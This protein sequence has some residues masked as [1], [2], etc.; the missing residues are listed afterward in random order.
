MKDAKDRKARERL[1]ADRRVAGK[2]ITLAELNEK[3]ERQAGCELFAGWLLRPT[4]PG[5]ARPHP[6][7]YVELQDGVKEQLASILAQ[8]KPQMITAGLGVEG[9]R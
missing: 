2:R 6:P 5:P 1:S 3:D 9:A 4:P 7:N 8:P